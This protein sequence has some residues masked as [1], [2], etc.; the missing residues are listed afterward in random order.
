MRDGEPWF[1][2]KDVAAAL[3]Y[4]KPANAIQQHCEKV[5]KITEEINATVVVLKLAGVTGN[6]LAI[7]AD[8]YFRNCTGRSALALSG[9]VVVSETQEQLLT[10]TEIGHELEKAFSESGETFSARRVNVLLKT[11]G[12]QKKR[13]DGKWEPTDKGLEVGGVLLDTGK[14]HGN[15]VPVCQLKWRTGVVEALKDVLLNTLFAI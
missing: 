4:A 5:N 3:G 12:F 13:G 11:H 15:G 1:V 6:Q 10:P 9:T 14:K 8:N 2:A 7:A